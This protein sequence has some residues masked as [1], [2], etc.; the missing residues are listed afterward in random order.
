[1]I[2]LKGQ[3]NEAI[4]YTKGLDGDC[5]NQIKQY[6]D[7]P[8][9]ADTKVR[10]M[11]DVHLGKGAVVGFTASCN[12]YVVPSIIG[13]DIGCGVCAYRLGKGQVPFD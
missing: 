10:I 9:F 8:L 2:I 11:P 4:V 13:V 7:H 1:M 12:E 5:E 3:Y 6:L